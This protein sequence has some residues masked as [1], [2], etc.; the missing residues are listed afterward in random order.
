MK[1]KEGLLLSKSFAVQHS[2]GQREE[3]ELKTKL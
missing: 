1:L 3:E 2:L